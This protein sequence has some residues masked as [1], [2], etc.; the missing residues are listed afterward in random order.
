MNPNFDCSC[1]LS[2]E[3]AKLTTT[4]QQGI[5]KLLQEGRLCHDIASDFYCLRSMIDRA[6]PTLFHA[7]M[8][9]KREGED[10]KETFTKRQENF[11]FIL[12]IVLLK[13]HKKRPQFYCSQRK[14]VFTPK[15]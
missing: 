8:S 10:L 6:R 7:E 2:N 9:G 14:L 11:L 4:T 1:S 15:L 5:V 3:I 13:H 12:Y